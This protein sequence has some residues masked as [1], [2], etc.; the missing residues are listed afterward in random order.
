M[1]PHTERF[2]IE[3][4]TAEEI[5]DF[6]T[7]ELAAEQLNSHEKLRRRSDL[8]FALSSPGQTQ[9]QARMRRDGFADEN[10]RFTEAQTN[11]WETY[12]HACLEWLTLHQ[13]DEMPAEEIARR[14]EWLRRDC[15][16]ISRL[17]DSLSDV[18]DADDFNPHAWRREGET[19]QNPTPTHEKIARKLSDAIKEMANGLLEIMTAA[20]LATV[21]ELGKIH[22]RRSRK[23]IVERMSGDCVEV[24]RLIDVPLSSV[25]PGLWSAQFERC[26]EEARTLADCKR[27]CAAWH[28]PIDVRLVGIVDTK[29]TA[30]VIFS[31]EITRDG[32]PAFFIRP[33]DVPS[34][35]CRDFITKHLRKRCEWKTPYQ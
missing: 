33:I 13:G 2:S 31:E 1:N 35:A 21:R 10:N 11:A 29:Q 5:R 6:A 12:F 16:K 19:P 22:I 30:S 15:P 17:R 32:L 23:F 7:S 9:F 25:H 20:D 14:V 3:T 8:R 24:F 4:A 34:D 26:V 18:M 27:V 28:A